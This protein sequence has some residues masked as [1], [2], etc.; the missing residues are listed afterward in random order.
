[1]ASIILNVHFNPETNS[2]NLN[3]CHSSTPTASM[4][5]KLQQTN[6]QYDCKDATNIF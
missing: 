2:E 6:S 5:V 1:M 4:I 3:D